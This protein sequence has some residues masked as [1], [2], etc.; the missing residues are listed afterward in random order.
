[1]LPRCDC[2]TNYVYLGAVSGDCVQMITNTNSPNQTATTT[3]VS[4]ANFNCQKIGVLLS[5]FY[6]PG[7]QN[8]YAVAGCSRD[9]MV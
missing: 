5:D 2:A 8:Y 9:L 3:T 6:T 7:T 4:L 1:M